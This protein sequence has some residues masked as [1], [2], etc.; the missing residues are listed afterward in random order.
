MWIKCRA[1]FCGFK[2]FFF[3][4]NSIACSLWAH[5][6]KLSRVDIKTIYARFCGKLLQMFAFN[7]KMELWLP[8]AK[9]WF[10]RRLLPIY[11]KYCQF[12]AK[13]RTNSKETW[14]IFILFIYCYNNGVAF[15]LG[16]LAQPGST[17]QASSFQ[18]VKVLSK[19]TKTQILRRQCCLGSTD[20]WEI[21]QLLQNVMLLLFREHIWCLDFFVD[22]LSYDSARSN[23]ALL[24][25]WQV[26]K[27]VNLWVKK[28][29]LKGSHGREWEKLQTKINTK[30]KILF[31]FVFLIWPTLVVW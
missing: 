5:I 2:I 10:P 25:G 21:S 7:C 8:R 28:C 29:I 23:T 16:H 26:G 19:S 9:V 22:T 30:K 15:D 6:W 20:Y 14:T 12:F 3:R 18:F 11:S 24:E 4:L 13:T 31:T 1:L 17:R 27:F